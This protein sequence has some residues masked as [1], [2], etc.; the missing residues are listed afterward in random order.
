MRSLN[1]NTVFHVY[2]NQKLYLNIILFFFKA[3]YVSYIKI[4]PK[5]LVKTNHHKRL[6]LKM[7]CIGFF[8]F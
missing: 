2:E 8:F 5:K 1:F 7:Y 4:V 3:S 6:D